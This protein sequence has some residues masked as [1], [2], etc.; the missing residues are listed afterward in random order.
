MGALRPWPNGVFVSPFTRAK[1]VDVNQASA[2]AR[3]RPFR[4]HGNAGYHSKRTSR[5]RPEGACFAFTSA[6]TVDSNGVCVP[7]KKHWGRGSPRETRRYACF[8]AS[9]T[10][11]ACGANVGFH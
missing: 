10:C 1:T 6:Q 8:P 9:L 4:A 7:R 2:A 3:E 5:R 11:L